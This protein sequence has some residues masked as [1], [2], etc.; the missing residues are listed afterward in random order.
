QPADTPFPAADWPEAQ[1][2]VD[3]DQAQLDLLLTQAFGRSDGDLGE[4]RALLIV[5]NGR[6]VKER[7][8]DG[9]DRSSRLTSW[10][11]AKS[12]TGALA[13]AAAPRHQ[14][15]IDQP[16]GNPHWPQGDPRA[17]IPWRLWMQMVDGQPWSESRATGVNDNDSARM[18][19]GEGRNDTAAF[20]A[21]RRLI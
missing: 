20:G 6:I 4:T 11:M 15:T 17:A 16:M 5:Q 10:S 13:G 14:V 7:Y 12:F 2:G 18:L 19:F 21:S 1:L 8:G 3:V 9:Y